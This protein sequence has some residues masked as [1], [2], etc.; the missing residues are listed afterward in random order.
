MPMMMGNFPQ[1]THVLIRG[2]G[3]GGYSEYGFTQ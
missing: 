1:A 3:G 2:G